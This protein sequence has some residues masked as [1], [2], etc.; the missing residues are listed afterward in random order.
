MEGR[1]LVG[2]VTGY[3]KGNEFYQ[4][5][6]PDARESYLRFFHLRG[7]QMGKAKVGD[8]VELIYV[9]TPTSGLWNVNKVL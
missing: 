2:V 4:V 7:Y 9:V 6:C 3:D 1:T 8:K 5:E